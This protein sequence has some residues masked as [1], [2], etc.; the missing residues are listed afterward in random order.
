MNTK[1]TNWTEE[2]HYISPD[3]EVV[4]IEFEQNMLSDGSSGV[5]DFGYGGDL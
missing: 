5:D 2:K 1:E 4:V 3:F